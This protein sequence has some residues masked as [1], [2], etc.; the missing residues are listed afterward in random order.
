LCRLGQRPMA[1]TLGRPDD[2]EVQAGRE[3]AH[4]LGLRWENAESTITADAAGR[5]AVWEHLSG[6]FDG[7]S[8]WEEGRLVGALAPR[9]WTGC[10]IDGAVGGTTVTYLFNR[11]RAACDW[12]ALMRRVYKGGLEPAR[13]AQLIGPVGGMAL[14]RDVNAR[15]ERQLRR[16]SGT[17]DQRITQGWDSLRLPYH[18]GAFVWRYSFGCWPIMFCLDRHFLQTFLDIPSAAML[19]RKI[20]RDLL[21]GRFPEL[22]R[23]PVDSN[24]WR[25]RPLLH[26][27]APL[28]ARL[29][30][31]LPLLGHWRAG[32]RPWNLHRERRRYHRHFDLNSRSWQSIRQRAEASRHKLAAWC[33]AD[34]V[35]ELVPPPGQRIRPKNVFNDNARRSLLGLMLWAERN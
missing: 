20:E 32:W 1:L 29:E 4:R 8:G 34:D 16:F 24:S 6:G 35:Q 28:A 18:L 5:S 19:D 25:F 33:S 14:V 31:W 7:F 15:L 26:D 23:V 11:K 30:R 27:Q 12:D 17:V 21:V 9:F 3:V 2:H 13:L 10:C 22:A